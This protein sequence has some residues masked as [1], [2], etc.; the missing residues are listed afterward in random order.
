MRRVVNAGEVT[1][2]GKG[3]TNSPF[4]LVLENVVVIDPKT[5]DGLIPIKL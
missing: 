1:N 2:V 3:F 4:P 5:G